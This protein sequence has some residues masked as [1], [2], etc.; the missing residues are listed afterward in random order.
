MNPKNSDGAQAES[1]VDQLFEK[2][3]SNNDQKIKT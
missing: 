1:L 3:D 2:L